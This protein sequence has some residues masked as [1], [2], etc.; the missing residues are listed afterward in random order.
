MVYI[1]DTNGFRV[2]SHYFPAQFPSFWFRFDAA[3]EAGDV[4]SVREVLRE[5]ERWNAAPPWFE[6]WLSG[7]SSM[8]AALSTTEEQFLRIYSGYRVSATSLG[9]NRC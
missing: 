7:H 8:F 9:A 1:F 6:A 5:L 4:R 2:I 3:V